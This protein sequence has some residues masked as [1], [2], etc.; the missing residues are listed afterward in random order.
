MG[1]GAAR[2]RLWRAAALALLGGVALSVA[3]LLNAQNPDPKGI[4]EGAIEQRGARSFRGRAEVDGQF[5]KAVLIVL[6]KSPDKQ[7]VKVF[8]PNGQLLRCVLENG[9]T[10]WSWTPGFRDA[11]R[12]PLWP[13]QARKQRD[14]QDFA[15]LARHSTLRYAGRETVAGR[16]AHRVQALVQT[17]DGRWEPL[18]ELWADVR[19]WVV[20][21]KIRP[22]G[23]WVEPSS[24]TL[25]SIEYT[26]DFAAGTFDFQLPQGGKLVDLPAENVPIGLGQAEKR[27]AFNA[28]TPRYLPPGYELIRAACDSWKFGDKAVLSMAFGNGLNRFSIFQS[29][30]PA[31]GRHGGRGQ[32]GAYGGGPG[33]GPAATVWR[34]QGSLFILVGPLPPNELGAI[35]DSYR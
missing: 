7:L 5:G 15:I 30:A 6:V 24:Y 32:G 35:R 10:E 8:S 22:P 20:L 14:L 27:C 1:Q 29:H 9:D 25:T 12:R 16:A 33:G 13:R 19:T 31:E 2:V 21:A 18:T 17:P 34:S 4:F 28:L 11:C 3:A 26:G 23:S